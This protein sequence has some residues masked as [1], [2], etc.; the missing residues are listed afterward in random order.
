MSTQG[1]IHRAVL[2]SGIIGLKARIQ[3]DAEGS[4]V[5]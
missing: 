4:F 1:I 5:V 3:I 2:L